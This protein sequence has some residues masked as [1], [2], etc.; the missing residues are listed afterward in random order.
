MLANMLEY[1]ND[2]VALL[3][4]T[5]GTNH[6]KMPLHTGLVMDDFGNGLP[7]S[8]VLCQGESEDDITT[9]LQA[10][11]KKLRQEL[12]DWMCSCVMVVNAIAE[13]NAIK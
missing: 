2:S 7:G 13:I 9:W 6:M 1:G 12:Y 3:Y 5:F 8:M 11:L 10:P 4:T